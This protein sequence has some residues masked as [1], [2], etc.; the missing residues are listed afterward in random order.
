[1]NGVI[2]MTS[3]LLDTSL[4]PEQRDYAET[5]RS[6]GEALLTII[7]DILDF[8]KMEAGRLQIES[9]GFDLRLVMEEVNADVYK[10]QVLLA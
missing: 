3:L 4:S 7:N 1:M 2:G 6:S 8:S 5:V 9:A 10:R